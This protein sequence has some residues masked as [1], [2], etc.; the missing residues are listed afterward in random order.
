MAQVEWKYQHGFQALVR[1]GPVA[2]T[3]DQIRPV[4]A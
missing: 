3:N 2:F 1:E 4:L